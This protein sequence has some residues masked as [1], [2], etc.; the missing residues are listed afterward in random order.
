MVQ[1][2][3]AMAGDAG[4]QSQGGQS[5]V[6]R[7]CHMEPQ[8]QRPSERPFPG[9]EPHR[10]HQPWLR[11]T[12]NRAREALAHLRPSPCP[13]SGGIHERNWQHVSISW[14]LRSFV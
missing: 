1:A 4:G 12:E 14:D 9:V 7:G 3:G 2:G 11:L 5:L 10:T 13:L 8:E 6:S